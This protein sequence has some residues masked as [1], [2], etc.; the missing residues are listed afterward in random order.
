[1][2]NQF[3]YKDQVFSVGDT[4]NV[5]IKVVEGDKTRNQ[6]FTGLLIAIK[7]KGDNKSFTVRKIAIHGI[8]VE[9]IFPIMSPDIISITLKS[10]GLVR[11]SKLYYL[12]DR[13]GKEALRVKS[14]KQE[15]KK[16]PKATKPKATKK[17]TK[18]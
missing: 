10:R 6:V 15:A 16:K 9:K 7:N 18:A 12:R 5:T 8:G 14:V 17:A 13:K 4:L 2:A 3:T 11:R 1:M